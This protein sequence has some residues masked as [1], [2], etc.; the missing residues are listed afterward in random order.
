MR[1]ESSMARS[2]RRPIVRWGFAVPGRG[3]PFQCRCDSVGEVAFSAAWTK[4]MNWLYRFR[5]RNWQQSLRTG[6][7]LRTAKRLHWLGTAVVAF[8]F[9]VTAAVM[10]REGGEVFNAAVITTIGGLLFTAFFAF[11]SMGAP[12]QEPSDDTA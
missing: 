7:S 1:R 3:T 10:F 8:L 2:S 12:E 4:G 6:L 5:E 11:L 9:A